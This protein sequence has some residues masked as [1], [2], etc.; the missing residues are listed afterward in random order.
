MGWL[1]V[2]VL[3]LAVAALASPD[4]TVLDQS[5]CWLNVLERYVAILVVRINPS[6]KALT[7]TRLAFPLFP[8]SDTPPVSLAPQSI[9]QILKPATFPG[10]I[11]TLNPATLRMM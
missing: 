8:S 9:E 11:G 4:S 5:G 2:L 3:V 1:V 10:Q 6:N 7:A